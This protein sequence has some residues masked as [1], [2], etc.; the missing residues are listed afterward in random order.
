MQPQ[1]LHNLHPVASPSFGL[2]KD[3]KC[4]LFAFNWLHTICIFLTYGH[5]LVPCC[6]DK[7]GIT[8]NNFHAQ[9]DIWKLWLAERKPGTSR[10]YWIQVRDNFIHTGHFPAKLRLLHQGVTGGLHC[11]ILNYEARLC[12]YKDAIS[13]NS[14]AG[15]WNT[16]MR[17]YGQLKHV[18]SQKAISTLSV[19]IQ[20]SFCL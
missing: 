15:Q 18:F 10:K 12:Y 13:L 6:P 8:V 1:Y 4:L 16:G 19:C 5:P 9:S 3:A 7:R 2:S 17:C 20:L 14:Q 11:I